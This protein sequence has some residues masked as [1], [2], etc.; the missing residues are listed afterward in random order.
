MA[1]AG[2]RLGSDRSDVPNKR[3]YLRGYWVTGTGPA[4]RS[5][6]T[7]EEEQHPR[8]SLHCTD[9][10][11]VTCLPIVFVIIFFYQGFTLCLED[12]LIVYSSK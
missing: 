10:S 3:E 9:F 7:L 1:R 4:S 12:L 2:D 11:S 8:G 5:E 6:T